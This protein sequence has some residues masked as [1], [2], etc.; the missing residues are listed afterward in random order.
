MPEGMAHRD[1]ISPGGPNFEKMIYQFNT[2]PTSMPRSFYSKQVGMLSRFCGVPRWLAP[3]GLFIAS[4]FM[5]LLSLVAY[6]VSA[7]FRKYFR[8]I[9]AENNAPSD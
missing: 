2:L 5:L 8:K 4:A 7:R 3:V 9:T 1:R 6:C